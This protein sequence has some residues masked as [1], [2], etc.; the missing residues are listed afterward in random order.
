MKTGKNVF[1]KKKD[2]IKIYNLHHVCC[3][4]YCLTELFPGLLPSKHTASY[5]RLCLIDVEMMCVY[6][7]ERPRC[8]I[9]HF[10]PSIK[11]PRD[12]HGGTSTTSNIH[13]FLYISNAFIGNT[14]LKLTKHQANAK[15]HPEA[16]L[17]TFENYSDSSITL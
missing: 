7:V 17:L 6:W 15:Q 8:Q 10:F 11:H 9:V 14:R 2:F 1:V 16:E 12:S 3:L 5:R 13:A 4:A